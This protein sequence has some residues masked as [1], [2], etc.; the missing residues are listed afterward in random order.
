MIRA[1]VPFSYRFD[2]IKESLIDAGFADINAVV[3]RLEKEIPDL[4]M[5]ARGL[6]YG[7]PVIDQIQKRGGI[8]AENVVD[9]I[10]QEFRREFGTGPRRMPLQ[11]I[12]FSAKKPS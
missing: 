11:A 6:V 1:S 2:P 7:S 3:L 4:E 5:F 8:E 9:A 10:V 12:V